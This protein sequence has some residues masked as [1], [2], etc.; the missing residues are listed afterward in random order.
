MLAPVYRYV[1][2]QPILEQWTHPVAALTENIQ[3][4]TLKLKLVR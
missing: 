4:Q 3:T 2:K 1:I